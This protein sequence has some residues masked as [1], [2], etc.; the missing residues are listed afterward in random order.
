MEWIKPRLVEAINEGKTIRERQQGISLYLF[1][2]LLFFYI[3]PFFRSVRIFLLVGSSIFTDDHIL[4]QYH[5]Q[6]SN[7]D[8]FISILYKIFFLYIVWTKNP[9]FLM[10]YWKIKWNLNLN[11]KG[12]YT[13]DNPV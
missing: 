4:L 8:I 5:I 1:S 3:P 6:Q 10:F 7:V 9:T 13:M 11:L 12:W 2:S